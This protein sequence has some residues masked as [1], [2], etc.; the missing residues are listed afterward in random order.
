MES[1]GM[2]VHEGTREMPEMVRRKLFAK[3]TSTGSVRCEEGTALGQNG[4][5][6][7]KPLVMEG[8]SYP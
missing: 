3:K 4:R 6:S 7:G 1:E 8:E 2:H 5:A